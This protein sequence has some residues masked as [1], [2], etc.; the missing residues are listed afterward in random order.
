MGL[1]NP[2]A[3]VLGGRILFEGEDLLAVSE[4]RKRR[5]R[6][7]RIALVFQHPRR[8]LNPTRTIGAQ[9]LDV[10]AAHASLRRAEA[11]RRALQMLASVGVPDP[12]A[13]F[14]A[15]SFELSGGLCQRVTIALALAAAPSLLIADEP[16][17]GLDVTTQAIVLDLIA[18]LAR[19]RGL[20]L[21]LITH[22][23][24]LASER[25]ERIVVMHAGQV[26]E[27]APAA[28][29]VAEPLHPYTRALVAATPRPGLAI[30]DLAEPAGTTP[31]LTR[32]DLPACRYAPR[33]PLVEVR[34]VRERPPLVE[35]APGHSVAC[36][37][38]TP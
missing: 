1:L 2:A 25:C 19:E 6:G 35:V 26:V 13:R 24:A 11:R 34:C 36:W 12:E 17:T 30:A 31:D 4:A 27:S 22:D 37:A 10:L 14:H 3:K 38:V 20:A 8:A 5:L 7:G 28:A 15:Y 18:S 32:P 9:L 16:T 23:L 21:W 33:C 29:L